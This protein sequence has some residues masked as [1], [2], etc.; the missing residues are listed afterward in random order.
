MSGQLAGSPGSED[1]RGASSPEQRSESRGS[2]VS[3][4]LREEYEDLLKYAVVTPVFD[5]K[6]SASS[7]RV[8]MLSSHQPGPPSRLPGAT[9]TGGLQPERM[10]ITKLTSNHILVLK[11]P[12]LQTV[13]KIESESSAATTP[14]PQEVPT[15]SRPP[16]LPSPSPPLPQ[17][18]PHHVTAPMATTHGLPPSTGDVMGSH[19]ESHDS[20]EVI[21]TPVVDPE[22]VRLETQLDTWCLDLKRNIMVGF[23]GSTYFVTRS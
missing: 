7:R 5:G 20:D 9:L 18:H 3:S 11:N 10:K 16:T 17:S 15:P 6:A 23:D 2:S 22:T 12:F 4:G 21:K 8:V 14:E 1:E 13:S 19:D